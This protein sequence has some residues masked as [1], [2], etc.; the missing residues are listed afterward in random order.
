VV[1]ERRG[2]GRLGCLF[3]LL[4]IAGV[5]YFGVGI[6]ETY[7][8]FYRYRDAMA[9]QARF[10]ATRSDA[11]I[12]SH[13]ANVA[14]S[15]GLPSAARRVQILRTDRG[16]QIEARYFESVELPGTVRQIEFH[17]RVVQR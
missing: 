11:T 5:G 6:G 4:I 2:A 8:R 17:P 16:V 12:T 7:L 1:R 14:D 13:L 10:A 15:L 9:Q 3:I